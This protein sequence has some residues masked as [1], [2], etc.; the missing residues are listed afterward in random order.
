MAIFECFLKIDDLES[1]STDDVHAG[2]IEV[3]SFNWGEL[4]PAVPGHGAGAGAGKVQSREF[5]FVKR[6]DKASPR[7]FVACAT[8]RRYRQAVLSGRRPGAVRQDY[9]KITMEDVLVSS[10]EITGTIVGD[11]PPVDQVCLRFARMEFSC[12]EQKP[13]GSLGAEITEKFDFAA[14]R[15][16]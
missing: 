4:Q 13:D 14:G 16:F 5:Q 6:V 1:E 11:A 15:P 7:L 8:G 10:Y 12:R 3:E 9:L 2:E